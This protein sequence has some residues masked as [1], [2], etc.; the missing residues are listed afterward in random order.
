MFFGDIVET[1]DDSPAGTQYGND[2]ILTSRRHTH[3][4]STSRRRHLD[5]LCMS[6]GVYCYHLI[7]DA[8]I[9]YK[10]YYISVY[11]SFNL[12]RFA[13]FSYLRKLDFLLLLNMIVFMLTFIP[14][15]FK[16][17]LHGENVVDIEGLFKFHVA[18]F[19]DCRYI[20]SF[21]LASSKYFRA[22]VD[23]IS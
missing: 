1:T 20:C 11:V 3:V 4:A 14:F 19:F 7:V 12:S 16:L 17:V 9:L 2:V 8:C 22:L 23:C 15:L 21:R 5:V 13:N 6:G 18:Q 10:S